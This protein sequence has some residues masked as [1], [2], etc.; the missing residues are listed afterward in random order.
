MVPSRAQKDAGRPAGPPGARSL[1]TNK[2][3]RLLQFNDDSDL[4]RHHNE[5]DI[6]QAD[7]Q[8]SRRPRGDG[9]RGGN[10]V[11]FQQQTLAC[12]R[13]PRPAMEKQAGKQML[14]LA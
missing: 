7:T 9:G 6:I 8:Q 14:A 2:N 3:E 1:R 12:A 13:S 11:Q 5:A 4:L 10:P